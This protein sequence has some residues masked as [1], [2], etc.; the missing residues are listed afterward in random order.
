MGNNKEIRQRM[1]TYRT[2]LLVMNWIGSIA[3]VITGFVLLDGIGGYAAIIIIIAIILGIVGHFLINVALA[4]PFILLNNGD[5]LETLKGNMGNS[6]A[7][8][9]A[10]T[11]GQK[12]VGNKLQ[13]KCTRCKKEVDEDYSGCPH[14]GNNTFE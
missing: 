1:D 13:K 9:L 7:S 6:I 12:I 8:N 10:N 3:G 14:C 11:S 5:T 4:I 2:V